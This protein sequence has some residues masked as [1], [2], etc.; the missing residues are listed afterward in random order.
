MRGISIGYVKNI[1]MNLNTI[2]VLVHIKSSNI[3]VPKNAIIETSQTGLLNDSV[4][5]IIPLEKILVENVKS[6]NVFSK[7]CLD[8]KF[9]C[10]LSHAYGERGLNYDDLVR[11]ATRIS[12]RFDDPR[13]FNL[14]YMF[15]QNSIEISEDIVNITYLFHYALRNFLLNLI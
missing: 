13:F 3:F 15:L 10:N 12:Q 14:C 7:T 6:V 9:L 1:K 11:A 8:S 4:I 5:D 2:L